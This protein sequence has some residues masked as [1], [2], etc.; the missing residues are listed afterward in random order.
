MIDQLAKGYI[1]AGQRGGGEMLVDSLFKTLNSTRRLFKEYA[2]IYKYAQ[3]TRSERMQFF[4]S[5]HQQFEKNLGWYDF[6]S[7][8]DA[9]FPK[10]V[11]NYQA[12]FKDLK[13]LD[14]QFP[15]LESFQ[16]NASSETKNLLQLVR[17]SGKEN[18]DAILDFL[19]KNLVKFK[20][21]K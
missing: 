2:F 12:Q 18:M 16:L 19:D 7:I 14:E 6:Q 13:F 1:E 8:V 17:V 3:S 4:M 5:N 10:I 15:L 21:K 9:V 11:M 20:G